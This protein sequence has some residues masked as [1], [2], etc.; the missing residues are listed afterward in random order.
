MKN[1]NH[2][3]TQNVEKRD[4]NFD[5]LNANLSL[6]VPGLCFSLVSFLLCLPGTKV[7]NVV[8]AEIV[9]SDS[10]FFT[11]YL[12]V[13][14]KIRVALFRPMMLRLKKLR[15]G[16]PKR[17]VNLLVTLILRTLMS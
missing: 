10:I 17:K 6:T 15:I 12:I 3:S 2:G 4:K 14:E 16:N 9:K 1:I 8:F 13:L 11:W 7:P 5:V